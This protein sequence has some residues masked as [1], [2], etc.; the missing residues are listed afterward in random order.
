[1]HDKSTKN[2]SGVGP[3]YSKTYIYVWDDEHPFLT[4]SLDQLRYQD[5]TNTAQICNIPN[6][7][8]CF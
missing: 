4:S 7:E 8:T 5:R 6:P 3:F 2:S 1:M